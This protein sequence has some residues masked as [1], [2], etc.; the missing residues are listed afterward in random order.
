[1]NLDEDKD[2]DLVDFRI[3]SPYRW[4]CISWISDCLRD[5]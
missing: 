4:K 3:V 2:Q 1:M 5:L